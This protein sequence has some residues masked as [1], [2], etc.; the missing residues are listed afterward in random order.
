MDAI[1]TNICF[2]EDERTAA[3]HDVVAGIAARME[4]IGDGLYRTC[5]RMDDGRVLKFPLSESGEFCNDG[6]ASWKHP[7]YASGE[8][9]EEQG[10]ICVI[11]EYITPLTPTE[12]KSKF[13]K[14]PDWVSG[15]DC[16][17]VGVDGKGTLKAYDF[18]HP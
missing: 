6:E 8:Y 16:M 3:A 11:Q 4:F 14:I 12:I 17:Q 18:V 7:T 1:L 5:F 10:F 2:C 9:H 15:I 13:G